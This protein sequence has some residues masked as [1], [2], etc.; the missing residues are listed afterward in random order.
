MLNYYLILCGSIAVLNGCNP[1]N[2]SKAYVDYVDPLIGTA[3]STTIS[4]LK[5]G[6]GTENNAQVVPYVTFP[7]GMTNWT[8]QTRDT[9]TK[10]V[11]P[12]YYTDSVIQGFRGSHWLSGSCVQ[13]YGSMTIMP[14]SGALKYLPSERG[15]EFS[16]DREN[17]SPYYYKVH[18][19]DYD[20]D[21]EVTATRRS[22]FLRFT[23]QKGG[24]AHIVLNPNSDEGVGYIRVNPENNEVE[25]YNPVHRIYQGWG[26][27]AGFS[28]YFVAR[29]DRDFEKYGVYTDTTLFEGK[30]ELSEMPDLGG[31]VSFIVSEGEK[32]G[33]KVGTSFTSIDQARKNL[34]TETARLDF[35]GAEKELNKEW[36]KYLSRVMVEGENEE[37]KVKFYTALYH[38]LLHP[39]TFNDCDGSYVSFAGGERVMNSGGSDYFVDFSMWDTYR[40]SHPLFNLLVPEIWLHTPGG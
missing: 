36:E 7:F 26:E 28:G 14:V 9:E 16:H 3:P 15:S 1:G 4:A 39:R 32:I 38:S 10:C 11:A 33:V 5:H 20:I 22:G 12:Y 27:P 29:F 18:L 25:G 2:H 8:P 23:F 21:A 30:S 24:E 34:E 35:E 31:Y 13:D 17:A 6:Q 40:A 37:D 19:D